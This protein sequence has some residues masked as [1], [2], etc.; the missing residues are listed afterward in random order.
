MF[1]AANISCSRN[2]INAKDLECIEEVFVPDVAVLVDHAGHSGLLIRHKL[3]Q[4]Q[5]IRIDIDREFFHIFLF[6][7][8]MYHRRR[9]LPWI[10]GAGGTRKSTTRTVS[11]LHLQ[12]P[13]GGAILDTH[14]FDMSQSDGCDLHVGDRQWSAERIWGIALNSPRFSHRHVQS[15]IFGREVLG[16][17]SVST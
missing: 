11:H 9:R 2:G 10:R 17:G 1:E 3:E 8:G 12:G 14:A 13:P 15:L 16:P 7:L 5:V 4:R 6:V